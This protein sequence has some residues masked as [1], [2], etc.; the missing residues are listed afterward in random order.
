MIWIPDM[1]L[2]YLLTCWRPLFNP[3]T[4]PKQPSCISY[5]CPW[6]LNDVYSRYRVVLH[7]VNR[8]IGSWQRWLRPLLHRFRDQRRRRLRRWWLRLWYLYWG[9]GLLHTAGQEHFNMLGLF[10]L[11]NPPPLPSWSHS[12]VLIRTTGSRS[13]VHALIRRLVATLFTEWTPSLLPTLLRLQLPPPPRS[14]S[15]I[16]Q[17]WF[18]QPPQSPAPLLTPQ[19]LPRWPRP[20]KINLSYLDFCLLNV[21]CFGW[22]VTT[23]RVIASRWEHLNTYRSFPFEEGRNRGI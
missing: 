3:S 20:G 7:T 21:T 18:T 1:N 13:S 11:V 12:Q 19:R 14:S 22:N 5:N 4:T 9:G 16:S 15:R 2:K 6:T 17:I 23:S 8:C 10:H